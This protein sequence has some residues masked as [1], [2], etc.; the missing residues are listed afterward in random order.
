MKISVI[1]VSSQDWNS[2]YFSIVV[3]QI[4]DSARKIMKEIDI[5]IER[6]RF[7]NSCY[8]LEKLALQKGKEILFDE[9]EL[10][11]ALDSFNIEQDIQL[12]FIETIQLESFINYFSENIRYLIDSKMN[13]VFILN[14]FSNGTIKFN[15]KNKNLST[16]IA[17][18]NIT[19]FNEGILTSPDNIQNKFHV[20]ILNAIKKGTPIGW[21][22]LIESENK[23]EF[24][25]RHEGL[26]SCLRE[27]I[28]VKK[29]PTIIEKYKVKKNV[30][31]VKANE[32]RNKSLW[33]KIIN[34]FFNQPKIMKK[35]EVEK[36]KEIKVNIIPKYTQFAF[37]DASI[38]EP[39]PLYSMLEVKPKSRLET[40]KVSLISNRHFEL[41]NIVDV[42][43]IRNSEIS[44]R[45][46]ATISEQES[47]SFKIAE[48]FFNE[49]LK[50]TDGIHIELF[51]T[52]LEPAVIGTY[53]ALL[54]ILLKPENR[55]KIVVTPKIFKGGNI[56]SDL[57]S[58][59]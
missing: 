2:D 23:P 21:I 41:D 37:Q 24:L 38:S 18:S 9:N 53:R 59:Y 44:R 57:K 6:K 3:R 55:G 52:G 14:E 17:K 45:E 42:C 58:W 13:I 16:N 33:S 40:I 29:Q 10:Q 31:D 54:H 19:E 12:P 34:L 39:F 43:I 47:L 1:S 8:R 36:E 49:I 30:I 28:Y 15:R 35:I 51:H 4:K 25:L 11:K 56:Y 20:Q 26:I 5:G 22:N 50:N 7:N 27:H 32:E 46:E 48:E